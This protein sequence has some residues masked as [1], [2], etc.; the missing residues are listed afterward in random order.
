MQFM[1]RSL[2]LIPLLSVSLTSQAA[3]AISKRPARIDV[4]FDYVAAKQMVAVVQKPVITP[5]DAEAL[6]RVPGIAAMVQQVATYIPEASPAMF[7]R[8]LIAFPVDRSKR[9][10]FGLRIA[11]AN[12]A[13]VQSL[14]GALEGDEAAIKR[15]IVER[16]TQYAPAVG[17]VTVRVVFLAGGVSDG[18]VVE[19]DNTPT[20]YVALDRA[21]GDLAGVEQN[22]AHELYHALQNAAARQ[23][24]AADSF[25]RNVDRKPNL[26]KLIARSWWEGSANF[27][28]DARN[29][30]AGGSYTAMWRDRYHANL[31]PVR[32]RENFAMFDSVATDLANGKLTWDEAYRR[33]FGGD[34]GSRFYFVGMEMARALVATHGSDYLR[35]S[36]ARPPGAVFRDYIALTRTDRGLI[37]FAPDTT[38]LIEKLPVVYLARDAVVPGET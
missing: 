6:L 24:P 13:E 33:G 21:S 9:T 30:P 37:P 26:E 28:V 11:Y 14:L 38:R 2:Y 16:V 1:T 22:M 36:F 31:A 18:F 23:V 4:I 12:R 10:P 20:F 27:V 34:G 25:V 7:K 8:E 35:Q 5:G 17:R 15:R 32:L 29:L 19:G 3:T